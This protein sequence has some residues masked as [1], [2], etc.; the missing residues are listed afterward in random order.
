[1]KK[2]VCEFCGGPISKNDIFCR[3]CGAK[4]DNNEEIK[5]AIIEGGNKK[6]NN[7]FILE[8]I[9]ILLII[10][11]FFGLFFLFK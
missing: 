6:E 11:A 4:I 2:K 1:M 5:D 10:I 9:I 3:G 7:T 8:I